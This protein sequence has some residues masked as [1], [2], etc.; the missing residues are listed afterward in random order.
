MLV[1]SHTA[2]PGP[3]RSS[4]SI[5]FRWEPGSYHQWAKG[6]EL[7]PVLGLGLGLGL[8]LVLVQ[9]L[10]QGLVQ[11]PELVRVQALVLV[12]VTDTALASDKL[13]IPCL[14]CRGSA[15]G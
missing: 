3:N 7:V 10:V 4:G 2:A 1:A 8:V 9:A 15:A 13:D 6:P 11:G 5:R 14:T 12:L